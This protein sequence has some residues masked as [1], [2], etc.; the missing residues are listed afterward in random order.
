M[1]S[2]EEALA[3]IYAQRMFNLTIVRF[4]ILYFKIIPSL[5]LK[6]FHILEHYISLNLTNGERSGVELPILIR[7]LLKDVYQLQ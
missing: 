6:I 1:D 5:F 3:P 7:L 4:I 2:V